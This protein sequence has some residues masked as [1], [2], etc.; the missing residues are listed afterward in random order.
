MGGVSVRMQGGW[1]WGFLLWWLS[2]VLFAPWVRRSRQTQQ[3]TAMSDAAADAADA[4]AMA[5]ERQQTP[6]AVCYQNEVGGVRLAGEISVRA[7]ELLLRK[8][9]QQGHMPCAEFA[10]EKLRPERRQLDSA[11]WVRHSAPGGGFFADRQNFL[12]AAAVG[13]HYQLVARLLDAGASA[14]AVD[15]VGGTPIMRLCRALRDVRQHEPATHWRQWVHDDPLPLMEEAGRL[16]VDAC[17]REGR[18]DVRAPF[19]PECGGPEGEENCCT[20]GTA[21]TVAVSTDCTLIAA[22][23]LEHGADLH[24]R[25]SANSNASPMDLAIQHN[26]LGCVPLL[27]RAGAGGAAPGERYPRALRRACMFERYDI[28]RLVAEASELTG[29]LYSAEMVAY[30]DRDLASPCLSTT[31]SNKWP[32]D[33]NLCVRFAPLH[34][35]NNVAGWRSLG[36]AQDAAKATREQLRAGMPL[37]LS[38]LPPP[39]ARGAPASLA[40]PGA[41]TPVDVAEGILGDALLHGVVAQHPPQLLAAVA[42]ARLVV[43]AAGPWS[44]GVHEL[45]PHAARR[46][47]SAVMR[48]GY[49]LSYGAGVGAGI[50]GDLWVDRVLPRIVT[51][52]SGAPPPDPAK[53]RQ[54][55]SEPPPLPPAP[56]RPA[57][58]HT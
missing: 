17:A 38:L 40:P 47:A 1:M 46:Y 48:I 56:L 3:T 39:P 6:C 13:G 58:V 51:R 41:V 43:A 20:R 53:A 34:V 33:P 50:P 49:L 10:L 44:R 8:A 32:T 35:L 12:S 55:R 16:L 24:G 28:A 26:A 11:F 15:E 30:V 19:V 31:L 21:F 23:L 25:R 2:R 36:G 18:I 9:C 54:G 37:D 45:Y 7:A 4:A 5:G 29:E 57:C 27:L 52:G 22:L 42:C 14:S